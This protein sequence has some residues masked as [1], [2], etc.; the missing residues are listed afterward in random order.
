VHHNPN[1]RVAHDHPMVRTTTVHNRSRTPREVANTIITGQQDTYRHL[2][3]RVACLLADTGLNAAGMVDT[4][5]DDG[6]AWGDAHT[7]ARDQVR[8]FKEAYAKRSLKKWSAR[9]ALN[10]VA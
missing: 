10:A 3:A 5:P 9:T 4:H 2:R 7:T 8:L 6:G 1:G